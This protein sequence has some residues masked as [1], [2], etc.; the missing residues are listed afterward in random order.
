MGPG[1]GI[2]PG[3]PRSGRPGRGCGS[4]RARLASGVMRS[5]RLPAAQSPNPWAARLA[6]RRAAGARLLDLTESNPT[7]VGLEGAGPLELAALADPRA[8]RYDP[9]PRGLPEAREAV[10]RA[11][12]ERGLFAPPADLVLTAGTSESYAQIFRLLGDPGDAFLVPRPSYPL[13]E[14]LADAEGVRLEPYRLAWDGRWHLDLPSVERAAAGGGRALLLVQPNHPTGT[15]LDP[16]ELARVE[17]LCTRHGLALVSDEVFGEF[18]WPPR[19]DPLPSLLGTPRSVPTFVLSGLSKS[20]GMPQLK[21][22]WIAVSGPAEARA[23]ALSGLEW[24]AD[25]F[26]SVGTPVQLAL[27]RLLEAGRAFRERV[28]ERLAANLGSLRAAV[29]RRPEASLLEA[30]GGWSAILRLPARRSGEAWAL[31]LLERDVIVHPD[32]FYDLEGGAHVVLSL[33]VEPD[34]LEEGLGRLERALADADG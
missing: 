16:A 34:T 9:D 12:A 28:A 4:A 29:A 20:C 13:F 26:L 30:E 5:R 6:E 2:R 32:H 10:S 7:R 27:P 31:E 19:R 22:G 23:E 15:C 21:L 1:R 14:P 18:P 11:Y 8:A 25:L 3:P 17:A 24:L 33:I